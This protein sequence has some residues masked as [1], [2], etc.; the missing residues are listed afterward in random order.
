MRDLVLPAG[1]AL[2]AVAIAIL[3]SGDLRLA[4]PGHEVYATRIEGTT[5]PK[6]L[7][8]PSGRVGVLP[9]PPERI[10][11]ATLASDE[12][13]LE[14]VGTG[15]LVGVTHFIDDPH[16]SLDAGAVPEGVARVEARAER[17]FPLSPDLV[18]VANYTRAETVHLTSAAGVPLLRLGAFASFEDV[19]SNIGRLADTTG[20]RTKADVW[21]AA[22]RERVRRVEDQN[23]GREKPRVLYLAGATY[24]AGPGSLVDEILTRAGAHNCARDVGLRGSAPLS[25][26]LAIALQPE[27]VLVTG[28][29]PEHGE[30]TAEALRRDPRWR[31][32]PAIRNHRVHLMHGALLLS[33]THHVVDALE[34][35]QRLIRA[36][37]RTRRHSR[38]PGGAG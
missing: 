26:E 21:I 3:G 13:L 8:D 31:D 5:F 34:E 2:V 24:S 4:L 30:A 12:I 6:R 20:T 36:P 19:Y 15:P 28:W 18:V 27:I 29:D 9:A 16:L 17:L 33:V 32:V 1:L 22:L 10:A 25:T 37:L 14:L 11:S 38:K 35:V 7:L 23:V